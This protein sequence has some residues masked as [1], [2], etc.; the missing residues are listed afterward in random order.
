MSLAV[1]IQMDP[2]DGVANGL[3]ALAGYVA[4]LL[5]LCYVIRPA[6]PGYGAAAP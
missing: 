4:A 6:A 2:I 3:G 5:V 1:A